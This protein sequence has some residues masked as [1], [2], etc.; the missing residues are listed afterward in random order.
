MRDA[1]P[2]SQRSTERP[3]PA[4]LR[5]DRVARGAALWVTLGFVGAAI[6]CQ[7]VGL[8]SLIA[9][10]I[11]ASS[12]DTL[13][14][15]R[16]AYAGN[17]IETGSLHSIYRVDPTRCTSLALDRGANRIAA[18]RCPDDGLALRLESESDRED[19]P[20]VAANEAR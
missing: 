5:G 2:L 13:P 11:H 14:D 12:V 9:G 7:A 20:L 19:L 3:T 15:R 10:I 1:A 4:A 8:S 17:Q 16:Q 18:G 6:I